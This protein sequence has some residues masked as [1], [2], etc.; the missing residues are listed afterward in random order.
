MRGGVIRDS[1][2]GYKIDNYGYGGS[3]VI[4]GGGTFEMT[5]GS[6]CDSES[7]AILVAMEGSAAV[8]GGTISGSGLGGLLHS[9][10]TLALSGSP[11][12]S[13]NG[14]ADLVLAPGMTLTVSGPLA[15]DNPLVVG[16]HALVLNH[17][18]EELSSEAVEA[19]SWCV[20][21]GV[22]EGVAD[23]VLAPQ[24]TITRAQ[25]VTM[26]MRLFVRFG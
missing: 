12:F 22:I 6:L 9:G 25:A 8:S 1:Q 24:H 26:L 13:D 11:V 14:A 21:N 18:V 15:L 19:V 2:I 20:M 16:S 10:G 17:G 3:G 23:R 5:G 7:Y 4:L